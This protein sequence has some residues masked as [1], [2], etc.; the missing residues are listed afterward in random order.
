MSRSFH[1]L[2]RTHLIRGQGKH[3]PT[4]LNSWEAC[5]FDFDHDKL[6]HLGQEAAR[7]GIELLVVDDGWFGHREDETTSLGDWRVNE[8]KLPGGLKRLGEE[9]ADMGAHV[10]ACPSHIN[11]RT[12]PFQL[13]GRA[14]LPGCFGYELDQD[15]LSP[16]ERALYRRQD[17]GEIH[18]GAGWMHGGLLIDAV[19]SDYLS[20]L[21]VLERVDPPSAQDQ[22]GGTMGGTALL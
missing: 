19:Q 13:R 15:K 2:F 17:T 10:A 20:L 22:P 7:Y 11:G 21:V 14:S 4:L 1:D 12:T 16:E 18:T 6:L 3:R 5:Y 8:E 9:L